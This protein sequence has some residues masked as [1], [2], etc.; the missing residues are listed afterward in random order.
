LA[1][2]KPLGAD[3]QL[4]S[5]PLGAASLTGQSPY[6]AS[7]IGAD[8]IAEAYSHSFGTPVV[9]LRPFNTYG[10]R[11][12]S[13]AFIPT[14]ISQALT[15]DHVTL[16]A[17]TPLRDMTF[18]GDTVRGFL[19]AATT[20][21]IEGCTINLGTGEAHSVGDFARRILALMGKDIPIRHDVTRER[22]ADSEVMKLV[23]NNAKARELLAWMPGTSLGEGLLATIAFIARNRHLYRPETYTV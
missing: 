13:R 6:S 18:I 21:G 7:K 12:S 10:P 8:K 9:T 23:S 5:N 1:R 2:A 3:R 11:Q 17:L 4:K 20:P 15:Q 22:P 19:L 14:I 16:G